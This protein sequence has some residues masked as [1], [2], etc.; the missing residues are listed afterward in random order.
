MA[1]T[2]GPTLAVQGE[3]EYNAAMKRV[4]D[5]MTYVKAEA[6]AAISVFNKNDKSVESLTTQINH[7]K[8]SMAVQRE[9]IKETE[10]ALERQRNNGVD[11]ATTAYKRMEANLNNA[12]A[13]LNKTDNEVKDL[14]KDLKKGGNESQ[15][16]GAKIKEFASSSAGQMLT[17]A[18]GFE[19]AKEALQALWSMIDN[20]TNAADALLTLEA[21]TGIAVETLQEMQY[22]A[23]FVDVEVEQM[24]TGLARTVKAIREA[25]TAGSDYITIADGIVVSTK[26]QNGQLR[27]S[28]EVFYN[29]IDAIGNLANETDR[30]T[31]AQKI[32]GKSYQDIM[33]LVK[34]G[35]GAIKGYGKEAKD[36]GITIDTITVKALGKLD[37]KLEQVA[38]TAEA[39]ATKASASMIRVADF[40]ASAWESL[41]QSLD[42]IKNNSQL[43]IGIAADISRSS[44]EVIQA[45]VD[46]ATAI[47]NVAY[48]TGLSIDEVKAKADELSQFMIGQG[49]NASTAYNDALVGIADG[50]DLMA[51]KSK[52]AEDAQ[53]KFDASINAALAD[54]QA[55][56]AQYIAEV[57]KT[58]DGYISSMGGIFDAFKANTDIT[59]DQ[60]LANLKSQEK[61]ITEWAENIDALAKRNIDK[62]LLDSLRKMGPAAAG[63]LAALNSLS[64]PKL[65]EYEAA[66]ENMSDTATKEAEKANADMKYNVLK[67]LTELKYAIEDKEAGMKDV[68]KMLGLGITDGIIDGLDSTKVNNKIAKMARDALAT[69]KRELQQNSPSKKFIKVGE[70]VGEGMALGID[71]SAAGVMKSLSEMSHDMT[72]AFSMGSGISASIPR[73]LG[74]AAAPVTNTVT[75]TTRE[76]IRDSGFSPQF[77]PV[78]INNGDDIKTVA[79]KMAV[80]YKR[81][82]AAQGVA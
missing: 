3:A 41:L 58:A 78:Y 37:D 57:Q 53:A 2:L 28:E 29:V 80:E 55:K 10:A 72:S 38:A 46:Q 24:T 69:A 44:R 59:G 49:A 32:F 42:P 76:I 62:G 51:Y 8:N 74:A 18:G 79:Q 12:K 47:D 30:E 34:A 81:A 15:T 20:A 27:D 40:A 31:A 39:T 68:A 71:N 66:W 82:L 35:S 19:L 50:L 14:E 16:F 5:S 4:R 21:Q 6:N 77:G 13:A 23:R 25:S 33:P 65:R 73:S 1:Y 22:A 36:A 67:S 9:Q 48:I 43:I 56:N 52:L 17:L 75:S 45:Q 64:D 63:E 70:G 61:G 26:D 7:L 11:P 54:Y 60:L